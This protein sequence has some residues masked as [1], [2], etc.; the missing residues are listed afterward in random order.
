VVIFLPDSVPRI[1][2]PSIIGDPSVPS[3]NTLST[4]GIP[5]MDPPMTVTQYASA[6]GRDPLY[7]WRTQPSVRKVIEF[8]ARNCASVPWH[9]Y[10]RAND[11]D[12][13]RIQD[14][15]AEQALRNPG[16]FATGYKLWRDVVTDMCLY[17]AW[18][19]V[20]VNNQLT[21]I[22]PRLLS[23]EN[24]AFGNIARV[25]VTAVDSQDTTKDRVDITSLPIA[26][27]TG[28]SGTQAGGV[29]PMTTLSHLL[30]EQEHSVQW[31]DALWQNGPKTTG[32]L[33]RPAA[34]PVWSD[35][36]R[37][38][39]LQQWRSFRDSSAGGTPILEDGME[40]ETL[41]MLAPVDAQDL[42]GRQLVD[43][44][45]A[46][47]FHVP[48]ELV[49]AR[50]GTFSNI[51]AFR[52]MLFGPALGPR[53]EEMQQ[54][55]NAEIVPFLD[56]RAD[57]YVELDREAAMNGSF[58]EQAQILS[59][60]IGG[61]WLTR[62]EGRSKQNLPALPGGDEIITPLNVTAGGQASPQD[63]GTQNL[64]DGT[65]DPNAETT[66]PKSIRFSKAA[67]AS[68]S[69]EK[70]DSRAKKAAEFEK[71][72]SDLYDRQIEAVTWGQKIDPEA[73]HK[74]WD[75]LAAE[76]VHDHLFSA[77]SDSAV[78][79]LTK[80]KAPADA[81]DADVMRNYITEMAKGVGSSVTGAF[82]D[83]I[84][85]IPDD[86]PEPPDT[87]AAL[88]EHVAP[89]V[90]VWAATAVVVAYGFGAQ[91]AAHAS[92]ATTKTW[93][94]G[95]NPR[96]SHAEINGETVGFDE[97]FS[98]GLRWPGDSMGG[99]ASELVNCNCSIEFE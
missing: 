89:A 56:A 91:D 60:A 10:I 70:T 28:W 48:P 58:A 16:R 38:R 92:G 35:S 14:S 24:D 90:L 88:Q 63:S 72:I 97:P 53:L 77:A 49:G 11:T 61:P 80:M 74:E 54:A 34:A 31:R 33:K 78:D 79:V 67:A 9:A 83:R 45:V 39:F 29:S 40:F 64:G 81:W 25:F 42:Q 65:N 87:K 12:R 46:S 47:A 95:D 99:D 50:A 66:A 71:A 43:A 18:C 57:V 2:V 73:F 1:N 22:S 98:N 36:K 62:N 5:V 17:D 76:A 30:N 3:G 93:I 6:L 94:A 82:V 15:P 4:W 68:S 75:A 52:Q 55:V 8:I 32:L 85:A 86:T 13:Q 51:A 26:I 20:V 84:N 23:L 41:T 59:T 19:V 37:E 69:T 27:S 96:P 21:R 7:I 44:E